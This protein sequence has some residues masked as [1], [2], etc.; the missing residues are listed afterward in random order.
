MRKPDAGER[1]TSSTSPARKK[2]AGTRIRRCF[3]RGDEQPHFVIRLP[4]REAA[5]GLLALS[6]SRPDLT[7]CQ[8]TFSR[9]PALEPRSRIAIAKYARAY[10]AGALA[11]TRAGPMVQ[12]NIERDLFFGRGPRAAQPVFFRGCASPRSTG[13]HTGS[14]TLRSLAARPMSEKAVSLL[15]SMQATH[16][17]LIV[18]RARSTRPPALDRKDGL[19]C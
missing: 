19:S 1:P 11:Q 6:H 7:S 5:R 9:V 17:Q 16:F 8:T 10:S 15:V 2:Y 12:A 18:V 3:V 13:V 14:P 4:H